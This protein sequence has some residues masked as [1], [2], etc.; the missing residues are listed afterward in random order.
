MPPVAATPAQPRK[1]KLLLKKKKRP[2]FD[3]CHC[4]CLGGPDCSSEKT[5][6]SQKSRVMAEEGGALHAISHARNDA[7]QRLPLR[8]LDRKFCTQAFAC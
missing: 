6:P 7:E 4:Q 3:L 1:L 2:Q 8:A 5:N